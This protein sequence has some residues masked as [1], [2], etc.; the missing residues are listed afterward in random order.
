M[1]SIANEIRFAISR[2]KTGIAYDREKV[3]SHLCASYGPDGILV[4]AA[5]ELSHTIKFETFLLSKI[6]SWPKEFLAKVA[7][8]GAVWTS[9]NPKSAIEMLAEQSGN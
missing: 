5:T 7:R 4:T 9:V 2:S 8:P 3:P 1:K 6:D